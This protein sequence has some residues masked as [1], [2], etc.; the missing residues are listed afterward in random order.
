MTKIKPCDQP[1]IRLIDVYKAVKINGLKFNEYCNDPDSVRA[2]AI[3]AGWVGE[4]YKHYHATKGLFNGKISER[5][6]DMDNMDLFNFAKQKYSGQE[7]IDAWDAEEE[8]N[9]KNKRWNKT[10]AIWEKTYE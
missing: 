4:P 7:A 1:V 8:E 9:R 3:A 10:L 2:E 5:F 6:K